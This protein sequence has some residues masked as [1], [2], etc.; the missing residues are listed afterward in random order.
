MSYTMPSKV[1]LNSRGTSADSQ[2]DFRLKNSN[3]DCLFQRASFYQRF[4]KRGLRIQ[5][6]EEVRQKE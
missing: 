1:R 3:T 2:A 5:N 6:R 4:Q